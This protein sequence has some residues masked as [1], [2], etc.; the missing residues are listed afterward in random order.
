MSRSADTCDWHELG[1]EILLRE[2][3]KEEMK[4]EL[5][6]MEMKEGEDGQ[7]GG[8]GGNEGSRG[9]I[10]SPVTVQHLRVRGCIT[11]NDPG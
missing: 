8:D 11:Q 7:D 5:E 9:R 6:E 3:R 10:E 4:E 1:W 2:E